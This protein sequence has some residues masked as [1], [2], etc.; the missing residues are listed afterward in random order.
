M[1]REIKGGRELEESGGHN[2][3]GR[4]KGVRVERE[5]GERERERVWSL[6]RKGLDLGISIA[7][8]V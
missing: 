7:C 1:T 8:D 2:M 5:G 3:G 4:D 6:S